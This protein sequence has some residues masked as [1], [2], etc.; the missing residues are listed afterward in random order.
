METNPKASAAGPGA[1]SSLTTEDVR[2]HYDQFAWVYRRYWGDHIHHG[3]FINGEQD[4]VRAQE[5]MLRHCAARAAVQRGMRLADVGCGHGAT[6]GLLARE[7]SCHV[8]GLTV[9]EEQ[10]KLARQLCKNLNGAVRFEL[11]DAESY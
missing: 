6:A 2:H 9:S 4:V 11:A 5:A 10:V 1:A 3:L 7:Y 8:V